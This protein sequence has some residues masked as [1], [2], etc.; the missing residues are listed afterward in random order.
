M[1]IQLIKKNNLVIKPLNKKIVHPRTIP[2]PLPDPLASEPSLFII[3]SKI[4]SGK[5]TLLSNILK[6]Y[7]NYFLKVYFCSSNIET[8]PE[9]NEKIIKDLAYNGQF[10]F[11]QNRL[12]S[13]FNDDICKEI[14]TDIRETMKDPDYSEADEH[15]LIVV[16]DLS[17]AFLNLKSY[18]VRTILRTR[19]IKLSWIICTQRLR[20]I[21]PPIRNQCS[22]FLTF[23]TNNNKEI[24][25][26][27]EMVDINEDQL[28]TLIKRFCNEQYKF[29]FFDSSKNP[30]K[31]Y[32]GFDTE[33]LIDKPESKSIMIKEKKTRQKKIQ[34][35]FS[36]S[37]SQTD[38]N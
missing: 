28:T 13:D 19:H 9:T 35:T 27:S 20:Q 5:S 37:E 32:S 6:M 33:I 2:E 8:D 11:N 10:I 1:N 16:D 18:I 22:Y 14:V 26:M 3:S 34:K 30:P 36:D 24:D 7:K 31:Y 25:A 21:C 38:S 29:I 12:F 23:S 15:F 17:Q 4:G